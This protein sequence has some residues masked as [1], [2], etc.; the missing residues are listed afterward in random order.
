MLRNELTRSQ[1]ISLF[2]AKLTSFA[3]CLRSPQIQIHRLHPPYSCNQPECRNVSR[4]RS[5]FGAM[6]DSRKRTRP[7]S[8][9]N[10]LLSEIG[11]GDH[12]R[13]QPRCAQSPKSRDGSLINQDYEAFADLC[14]N[15]YM[16]VRPDGSVLND[17]FV[18]NKEAVPHDRKLGGLTERATGS[19]CSGPIFGH[20]SNK[21]Q[22]AHA[23]NETV[24]A[25]G[26]S[27]ETQA[28]AKCQPSNHDLQQCEDPRTAQCRTDGSS[29]VYA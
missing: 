12:A 2:F 21:A 16:L 10:R 4:L 27:R 29:R 11:D 14:A 3:K 8:R 13:V 6:T 18:I 22:R 28:K 5:A 1:S 20:L 26:N 19:D 25:F 9:R 17:C 7:Y 15:E 24:V 23:R